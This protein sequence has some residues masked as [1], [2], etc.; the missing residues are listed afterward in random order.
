MLLRGNRHDMNRNWVSF[1]ISYE[2]TSGGW[3]KYSYLNENR[4]KPGLNN[5]V[6]S[7]IT[8][9]NYAAQV[10]R[11]QPYRSVCIIFPLWR[12]GGRIIACSITKYLF[13]QLQSC[14]RLFVFRANYT[15]EHRAWTK[16][17][18]SHATLTKVYR[19]L[20]PISTF[21]LYVSNEPIH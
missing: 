4:S 14:L 1:Q 6:S 16:M 2:S 10:I 3:I 12:C 21:K 19:S 17:A 20:W 5:R 11:T 15:L 18:S 13:I 7:T 8:N 9:L